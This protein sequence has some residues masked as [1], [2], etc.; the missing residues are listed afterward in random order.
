MTGETDYCNLKYWNYEYGRREGEYVN[1][2]TNENATTSF[3]EL[4]PLFTRFEVYNGNHFT[5][6]TNIRNS[7]SVV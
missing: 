6:Q 4:P 7:S 5:T 2:R 1:N 3:L